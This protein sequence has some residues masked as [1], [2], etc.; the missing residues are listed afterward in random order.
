IGFR[1]L[2]LA[3]DA[4]SGA[5]APPIGR[6]T[7]LLAALGGL[8]IAVGLF[9]LAPVGLTSLLQDALGDG[10]LFWLV[11]G[12]VRTAIFLAYLVVITRMT[13]MRRVFEYHGAEHQAIA[14]YEAGGELTP[15][16]AARFSRLHPRC[17]TSFLLVAMIV[18]SFVFAPVGTPA[19]PWLLLSR[20]VGIPLVI[21]VAFEVQRLVGRHPQ[22]PLVAVLA[23]PGLQLQRLTTRPPDRDQLAVA[24]AALR[25]VLDREDPRA[26]DPR[27]R[28][29]AEVAA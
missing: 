13:D 5:D 12:L 27:E 4:Q 22:V 21:G 20:V 17:G 28:A 29:G 19:L 11:E 8:A 14:C 25:T 9:F 10:L 2:R 26:A 15:E 6:G 18:A 24:I 7:W 23:W 3:A 1:A 16:A